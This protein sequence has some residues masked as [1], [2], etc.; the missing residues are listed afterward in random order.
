M[1]D[2]HRIAAIALA[3]VGYAGGLLIASEEE[4]FYL[5]PSEQRTAPQ[6]TIFAK[7][8]LVPYIDGR[9][10]TKRQRRRA[11]GKSAALRSRNTP[12]G[13]DDKG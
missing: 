10:L 13:Q 11:R 4:S 1:G 2:L 6:R 5:P 3:S 12:G 9:P 7:P 8:R